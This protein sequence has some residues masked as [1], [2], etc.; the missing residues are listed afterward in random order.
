MSGEQHQVGADRVVRQETAGE[1]QEGGDEACVVVFAQ[2]GEVER[3]GQDDKEC[4]ECLSPGVSDGFH[5]DR[6]GSKQHSEGEDRPLSRGAQRGQ[7]E[8]AGKKHQE[9]EARENCLKQFEAVLG[10]RQE[11]R[12]D[13]VGHRRTRGDGDVGEHRDGEGKAIA[14]E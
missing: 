9:V 4:R 7:D 8:D 6:V 2:S 12:R 5:E 14:E 10:Q 3:D 13:D 11:E 1:R